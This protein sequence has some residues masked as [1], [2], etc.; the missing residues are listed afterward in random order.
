VVIGELV[1]AV[2]VLAVLIAVVRI[3]LGSGRRPAP[4]SGRR[5]AVAVRTTNGANA[6]AVLA[7]V[8]VAQTGLDLARR[9]EV[10]ESVGPAVVVSVMIAVVFSVAVS[11]SGGTL[12]TVI[13]VSAALLGTM[14]DVGPGGVVASLVLSLPLIWLLGLFRGWTR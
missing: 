1:G 14:I 13:G 3:A 11:R 12:L 8:A 7:A 2:L 4:F 5:A 6:A 10:S 9:P